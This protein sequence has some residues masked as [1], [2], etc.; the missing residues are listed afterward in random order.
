L[1]NRGKSIL[2]LLVLMHVVSACTKIRAVED[3]L[4]ALLKP[5]NTSMIEGKGTAD[6][7]YRVCDA[8][9]LRELEGSEDE[10]ELGRDIA[11]EE[12]ASFEPIAD[13]KGKLYGQGYAV[14]GQRYIEET[15]SNVGLFAEFNSGVVIDG[16][17]ISG[18]NLAG[19]SAVAALV[20]RINDTTGIPVELNNI[21]IKDSLIIGKSYV[22]GIFARGDTITGTNLKVANTTVVAEKYVGLVAAMTSNGLDL[23]GAQIEGYV[24]GS[25]R[26]GGAFGELSNAILDSVAVKAE[27]QTNQDSHEFA[28]NMKDQGDIGG[29]V[30]YTDMSVVS[31]SYNIGSVVSNASAVVGFG[32]FVGRSSNSMF[33]TNYNGSTTTYAVGSDLDAFLGADE[34]GNITV[35]N[36]YFDH[37]NTLAE[38]FGYADPLGLA[39]MKSAASF[40][41]FDTDIWTMSTGSYKIPV[42]K[43][44]QDR[45]AP[46]GSSDFNQTSSGVLEL[47]E[48]EA[49]SG[50]T[51]DATQSDQF[52]YTMFTLTNKTGK[53]IHLKSANTLLQD[54][55]L[56]A[57]LGL[58]GNCIDKIDSGNAFYPD[59][60]CD[61]GVR[62]NPW[63]VATQGIVRDILQ[64]EYSIGS[65]SGV[66]RMISQKVDGEAVPVEP[67]LADDSYDF[68]SVIENSTATYDYT[69]TNTGAEIGEIVSYTLSGT[70]FVL[71]DTDCP[72]TTNLATSDTC[73]LHLEFNP[74]GVAS[75]SETLTVV[76]KNIFTEL[77]HTMTL[78][79]TGDGFA[80][81]FHCGSGTALDPWCVGDRTELE[82]I[83]PTYAG[84]Y[85]I[86][87]ANIDLGGCGSPF[88]PMP[89]LSGGYDGDGYNIDNLCSTSSI[90]FVGHLAGLAYIK[91]LNF[92][93]LDVTGMGVNYLADGAMNTVAGVV[94]WATNS[95]ID[96]VHVTNGSIIGG[97]HA[98]GCIAGIMSIISTTY[99]KNSSCQATVSGNERVGGLLGYVRDGG[100][101]TNSSTSGSVTGNAYTGGVIGAVNGGS[102]ISG[103]SSS[104]DVTGASITGGLIGFLIG[105]TLGDSFVTSATTVNTTGGNAG[106]AIGYLYG[107]ST[108]NNVYSEAEVISTAD[109]VGGLIGASDNGPN[110][111]VRT[112]ATGDVSGSNNVGGL[113]GY[114]AGDSVSYSYAAGGTVT[115]TNAMIGGLIGL[116]GS[117][118]ISFCFASSEVL[119]NIT[120]GGAAGGLVGQFTSEN[121][122]QSFSTGNVTALEAAG[123][124]YYI[125]MGTIEDSFSTGTVTGVAGLGTAAAFVGNAHGTATLNKSYSTG[126]ASTAINLSA[127]SYSAVNVNN[128]YYYSYPANPGDVTGAV[129]LDN[130]TAGQELN[131]L[132]NFSGFIG[133]WTIPT[134]N[135]NTTV[136]VNQNTPV[137]SWACDPVAGNGINGVAWS[138]I[139]GITCP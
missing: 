21:T 91:N 109:A 47:T 132:A 11:L 137:P 56:M 80:N 96:N 114:T 126:T 97:A 70:A 48:S 4:M 28:F 26:A 87:D 112:Y 51:Y 83:Y 107:G 92:D 71:D 7:R 33:L 63:D 19:D 43:N 111:I 69:L 46:F 98:T 82:S 32:G 9:Q 78:T 102:A 59:D 35:G 88:T 38:K 100:E 135:W 25:F 113:I 84:N 89:E 49:V 40:V 138:A 104:A 17:V 129:G 120:T 128:I 105:S 101:V 123:F 93:A 65:S 37:A 60:T 85:F 55:F 66:K 36:K 77:E 127:S 75:Y 62:F 1:L 99:I 110:Q 2:M 22:G 117:T 27:V 90:G 3:E 81:P 118:S 20:G 94:G 41:G 95:T 130:L 76:Y 8:T 139:T 30:G 57:T 15:A 106:G 133:A 108:L 42:L 134:T 31:N 116:A 125:S 54:S 53:I 12:V 24:N 64:I 13:F 58:A 67:L 122:I 29:F 131:I 68:G 79:L 18:S 23:N 86:Q 72:V 45:S 115:G 16:L 119:G 6:S 121:I 124:V 103:I 39:E 61:V 14:T 10:W 34:G 73:D 136:P 50:L 5:C 74:T 44:V 52:A